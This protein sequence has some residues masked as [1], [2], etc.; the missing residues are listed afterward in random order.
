[1]SGIITGTHFNAYFP[2]TK[3]SSTMQGFVTA[4]YEIGCLFGAIFILNFGDRIGRRRVVSKGGNARNASLCSGCARDDRTIRDR[5]CEIVF[6]LWRRRDVTVPV[7][8][9]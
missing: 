8:L 3:D 6:S 9:G 5:H 1:M 2:Q 7:T 4:I